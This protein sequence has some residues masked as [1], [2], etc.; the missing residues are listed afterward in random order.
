[1]V[2]LWLSG[3]IV[4][5]MLERKNLPKMPDSA[6][7]R[8][9]SWNLGSGE[10]QFA[11]DRRKYDVGFAASYVRAC[12]PDQGSVETPERGALMDALNAPLY[13]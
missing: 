8:V 7:G 11:R 3:A 10:R 13:P 9:N 2:G 1:M 12:Q 5:I 6:Y 4:S